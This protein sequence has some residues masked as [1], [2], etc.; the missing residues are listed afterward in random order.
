MWLDPGMSKQ[1]A[2]WILDSCSSVMKTSD[3]HLSPT[4]SFVTHLRDTVVNPDLSNLEFSIPKCCTNTSSA[5]F[6]INHYVKLIILFIPFLS[7]VP[8]R[9]SVWKA[10]PVESPPSEIRMSLQASAGVQQG[11]K[12]P[13]FSEHSLFSKKQSKLKWPQKEGAA[14][15]IS[16]GST[17]IRRLRALWVEKKLG[18]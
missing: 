1:W 8:S 7:P 17:Q 4:R 10:I 15:P 3:L 6:K 13:T 14:H 9:I 2:G 16:Q 18:Y 5:T 12:R 11:G